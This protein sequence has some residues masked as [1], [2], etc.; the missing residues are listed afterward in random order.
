V[1]AWKP[2]S[3]YPLVATELNLTLTEFADP[4]GEAT[5]LKVPNPNDSRFVADELL[6]PKAKGIPA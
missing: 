4:E 2:G 6:A 1:K 5:F 3:W